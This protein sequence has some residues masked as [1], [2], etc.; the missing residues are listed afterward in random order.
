MAPDTFLYRL[1]AR[2]AAAC[3]Y[4]IGF[5]GA[6]DVDYTDLAEILATQLLN[7]VGDPYV[8]C[9]AAIWCAS[10]TN[11]CEHSSTNARRM[12]SG[13]ATSAATVASDDV[14]A[15]GERHGV[16]LRSERVLDRSYRARRARAQPPQLLPRN[17]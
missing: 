14:A 17:A 16:L 6:T 1:R 13:E 5:P 7:S 15:L 12:A 3:P 9:F 11:R 4:N 2:L 8:H 10:S